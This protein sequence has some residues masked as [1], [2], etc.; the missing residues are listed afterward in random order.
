MSVFKVNEVELTHKGETKQYYV[1][2]IEDTRDGR[3]ILIT[4]WCKM[5][6]FGKWKVEIGWGVGSDA[7][8]NCA[9]RVVGEKAAR[10]YQ[11]TNDFQS[12][13]T[14][15][16]MTK[17]LIPFRRGHYAEFDIWRNSFSR[18]D[19]V[20]ILEETPTVS[21]HYAVNPLWGAF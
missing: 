4:R 21:K 6:Y 9:K 1:T 5:G 10:D 13:M 18:E 15:Q 19:D 2:L 3:S 11:V 17:K 7:L 14:E 16:Q 12:T 8:R 20:E